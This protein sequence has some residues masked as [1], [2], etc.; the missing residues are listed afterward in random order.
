MRICLFLLAFIVLPG[1]TYRQKY[2]KPIDYRFKKGEIGYS[3]FFSKAV[4]LRYHGSLGIEYHSKQSTSFI[5]FLKE[6][7]FFDANGYFEPYG[8]SW[9]GEMSIA[10]IGDMLPY[11]Y[12]DKQ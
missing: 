4:N 1:T 2:K 12:S 11:D 9:E 7:V 8:I 10:R 6:S 5:N 3:A